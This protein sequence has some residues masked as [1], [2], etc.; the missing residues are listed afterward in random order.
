LGGKH[1][2]K[3]GG[4]NFRVRE[5]EG[6]NLKG[7]GEND[8]W[9]SGDEE[10]KRKKKRKSFVGSGQLVIRHRK[11]SF[12][13][14]GTGFLKTSTW[15]VQRR[16]GGCLSAETRLW[17]NLHRKVGG[18]KDKRVKWSTCRGMSS[19]RA[20]ACRHWSGPRGIWGK[21]V[22]WLKKLKKINKEMLTR[23]KVKQS[24]G[25]QEKERKKL[26]WGWGYNRRE[27][28]V[29]AGKSLLDP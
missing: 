1:P 16:G 5:K 9:E 7:T 2:K 24:R 10:R 19:R 11:N 26:G 4:S 22:G 18:I 17:K 14:E 27:G 20:K 12:I 23:G 15:D 28:K 25:S 8:A 6:L 13:G 29:E 21:K 3:K